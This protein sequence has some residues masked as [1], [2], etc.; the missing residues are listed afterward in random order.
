MN[1]VAKDFSFAHDGYFEDI[2]QVVSD[3]GLD[4]LSNG[5]NFSQVRIWLGHS[6][7]KVRTVLILKKINDGWHGELLQ[8]SLVAAPTNDKWE[9][10]EVERSRDI[11]PRSGWEAF[12]K[13]SEIQNGIELFLKA[14]VDD[15]M[16]CGG[17]DGIS[18]ILEFAGPGYYK[19]FETC[20]LNDAQQRFF[21][22]LEVEFNFVYTR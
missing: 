9:Y 13:S 17:A 12:L 11:F 14:T 3:L 4:N 18:Y 16:G 6:M 2:P 8:F 15:R 19:L 7:A 5:N 21:Y 20:K 22:K 1:R 10:R